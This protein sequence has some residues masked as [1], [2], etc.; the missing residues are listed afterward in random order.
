MSWRQSKQNAE[1]R[2]SKLRL[3]AFAAQR[4]GDKVTRFSQEE[5]RRRTTMKLSMISTMLASRIF[6]QRRKEG[7]KIPRY[8]NTYRLEPF[9]TFHTEVVDQ[10][11]RSTMES[12]LSST[13]SYQPENSSKLCFEIAADVQKAIGKKDY[14]R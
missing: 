14:D 11:V 6:F 10:I 12:K 13:T 4:H 8:Q 7:M 2:P 3:S 1:G 9:R 5:K